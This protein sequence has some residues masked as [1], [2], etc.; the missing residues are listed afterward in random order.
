ML[1]V[2]PLPELSEHLYQKSRVVRKYQKK[3]KLPFET[4]HYPKSISKEYDSDNKYSEIS[5]TC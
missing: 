2:D 1:E 3:K 5:Q 4:I